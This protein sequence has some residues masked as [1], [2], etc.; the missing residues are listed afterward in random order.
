M[1]NYCPKR[2]LFCATQYYNGISDLIHSRF[3]EPG[4]GITEEQFNLIY[5]ILAYYCQ[6]QKNQHHSL[7]LKILS[8][9]PLDVLIMRVSLLNRK[10]YIVSGDLRLLQEYGNKDNIDKLVEVEEAKTQDRASDADSQLQIIE[11]VQSD[12]DAKSG[13]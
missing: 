2:R 5:S 1:K 3:G 12:N 9:L 10:L 8:Y 6:N 13:N 4:L 11:E 7:L